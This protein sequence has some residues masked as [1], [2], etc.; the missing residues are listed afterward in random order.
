M[1]KISIHSIV[2]RIT[3]SSTVIYTFQNNIHEAK[4]LIQEILKLQGVDIPVNKLF[5][6]GVFYDDIYYYVDYVESQMSLSREDSEIPDDEYVWL[7]N[8][9]F[10][11]DDYDYKK[12]AD[13]VKS[14]IDKVL[15]GDI[16]KPSWLDCDDDENYKSTSLYIATKDIKYQPLIEKMLVF[17]NSTYYCEGLD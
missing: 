1:H 4:E 10:G 14:I 6:F 16:E 13:I 12:Q 2:H 5:Y 17:L 7:T 11:D 15:R 8:N 3:N 9:G